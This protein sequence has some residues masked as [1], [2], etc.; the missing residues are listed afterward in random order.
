LYKKALGVPIIAKGGEMEGDRTIAVIPSEHFH[1]RARVQ[2][3]DSFRTRVEALNYAF[4]HGCNLIVECEE[5]KGLQYD[6]MLDPDGACTADLSLE[7]VETKDFLAEP[8][9]INISW[10]RLMISTTVHLARRLATGVAPLYRSRIAPSCRQAAAAASRW[11]RKM[12]PR[13]QYAARLCRWPDIERAVRRR[14][15]MRPHWNAAHLARRFANFVA[16]LSLRK[17][18][19]FGCRAAVSAGHYLRQLVPICRRAVFVTRAWLRRMAPRVRYAA[20]RR[21]RLEIQNAVR[22]ASSRHFHW[23]AV[24]FD[25]KVD[26]AVANV[27]NQEIAPLVRNVASRRWWSDIEGALRRPVQKSRFRRRA[28]GIFHVKSHGQDGHA[29]V[30]DVPQPSRP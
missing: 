1:W 28:T 23:G 4:E 18:V 17:V 10:T 15:S 3:Q 2:F 22:L 21:G 16:D 14:W 25:R 26:A 27:F 7:L 30:G 13:V 6:V 19:L 12:A 29:A 8:E 9:A 5:G 11:L 20:S 24:G